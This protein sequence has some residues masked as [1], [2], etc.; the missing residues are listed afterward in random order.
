MVD[1]SDIFYSF[2]LRG[3]GEGGGVR[4][5]GGGGR[6]LIKNRGRGRGVSEEKARD[7]EGLRGLFVGRG[8]G[9]NFFF[10]A[11][12]PTKK[13]SLLG[14]LANNP[15]LVYQCS[16][17]SP[18]QSWSGGAA[19]AW[20]PWASSNLAFRSL[21][22]QSFAHVVHLSMQSSLRSS[23]YSHRVLQQDTKEYPSQRSTQIGVFRESK[24]GDK[25]G[26]EEG[27]SGGKVT[28]AEGVRGGKNEGKRVGG[29]GPESALEKF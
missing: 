4:G 21:L 15:R 6:F 19:R 28:R 22:Y 29:K 10:G 7:G 27:G 17:S 5:A 13:V 14:L 9:A 3:G 16:V 25:G 24:K 26:G 18:H 23:A 8:G 20:M 1:V 11:E 12:M 2:L